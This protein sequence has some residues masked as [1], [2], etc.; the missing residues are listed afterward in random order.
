MSLVLTQKNQGILTITLNEPDALNAMSAD[1]VHE[2]EAKIEDIKKQDDVRVVIL[3]GAGRA[4][5]SGGN[6]QMLQ[7]KI[8]QSPDENA[9]QLKG[10]YQK[11]L[12][13]MNLP[14]P[15]IAAINGAAVGAGLCI[16]LACD[17]RVAKAG[18]KLGLNFSKIGLAPGMAGTFLVNRILPPHLAHEF[19]YSGDLLLAEQ[20]KEWGLLNHVFKKEDFDK[21]LQALATKFANNGP[22]AMRLIKKGLRLAAQGASLIE[23]FDFDSRA[24]AE[25][26]ATDDIKEGIQAVID[27]RAPQF[28]NH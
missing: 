11:F 20:A 13:I 27:K 25:C 5:S 4:F 1:M 26:F 17:V 21:E 8:P 2:F 7:E 14:Q 10:F 16:A 3:T 9:Q 18:A 24:Q 6:L 15:T 22:K 28:K 12:S 23:V 19:L